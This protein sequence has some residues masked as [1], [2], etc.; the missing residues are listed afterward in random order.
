MTQFYFFLHKPEDLTDPYKN[1]FGGQKH[2][3]QRDPD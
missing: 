2:C 1:R 3:K